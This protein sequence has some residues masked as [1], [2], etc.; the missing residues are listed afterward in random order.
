[1]APRMTSRERILAAVRG[2]PV[3][4]APF[5]VW[6]HFYPD[7][8]D[9]RSLA[10][11]TVAFTRRFELD[12]VKYNPRAD[13]HAEP[14]GT[15]TEYRGSEKPTLVRYAVERPED[16]ARIDRRGID[17]PAFAELLEG[18]RL[19]RAELGDIPIVATIFTPLAVLQRMSGIDRV[20]TDMRER[21]ELV[22]AALAA[23]AETFRALAAACCEIADGIF[24]ATTGWA[25]RATSD[26][27]YA[28]FGVPYDRRVLEGAHG[29]PL[30]VLHVCADRA[31]V[32]ELGAAYAD[33][34]AVSWSVYGR[35]NPS[36]D[37]FLAAVPGPA[38]VGG[39]SDGALLDP[40]G[41]A[42]AAEARLGLRVTGGRR[43]ICAGSCTIPVDSRPESIDAARRSL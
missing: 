27:D 13:Y 41:D 11:A 23:V 29:A 37:A 7:E 25:T 39:L 42:T 31:R 36:L 12:L 14:W 3:D 9:A 10:A 16:W 1:M 19:V 28:R 4:R 33:I 6:R 43:W 17:E 22:L 5:A 26:A 21:P 34:A 15:R 38:A 18:M 20:T 40:T 2:E 30:N 35:E 24:L 8:A 32:L